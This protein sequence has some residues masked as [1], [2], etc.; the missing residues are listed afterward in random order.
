MSEPLSYTAAFIIGLLGSTHCIGMCGGIMGALSFAVPPEKRLKRYLFPILISYNLGRILSYCT[1]GALF[2]G[3]SWLLVDKYHEAGTILRTISGIMLVILGLS[4]ANWVHIL[5]I[6]E[7]SGLGLWQW[8]Q[9]PLKALIPVSNP[10]QALLVGTLWGWIPCGLIY[11][12]LIWATSTGNGYQSAMIMLCFGLGTFPA[13]V[14]TGIFARPLKALY[15][16][17]HSRTLAG[18]CIIVFGI[19]TIMATNLHSTTNDEHSIGSQGHH[20]SANN[21]NTEW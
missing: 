3:L 10:F 9:R 8:L 14:T 2:G 20:P 13:L 21:R 6:I 4:I 11:S 15:Q 17:R 18:L 7:K 16:S 5:R 1:A 12:T 19:W